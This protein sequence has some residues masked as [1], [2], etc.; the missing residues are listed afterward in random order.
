MLQKLYCSFK[1]T[2]IHIQNIEQPWYNACKKCNKKVFM[3]DE[4]GECA[5]CCNAT[6]IQGMCYLNH[7]IIYNYYH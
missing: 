1:A 6:I 4:I 5:K 7:L 3:R 2:I